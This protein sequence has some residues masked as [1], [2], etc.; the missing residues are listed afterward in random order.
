MNK[1]YRQFKI[2]E[3][4]QSHKYPTLKQILHHLEQCSFLDNK[5]ISA[6]TFERDLV[7]IH[8]N[9]GEEIKYDSNKKGYYIHESSFGAINASSLVNLTYIHIA[10]RLGHSENA[11]YTEPRV[12]KGMQFFLPMV[13]AIKQR[14]VCTLIHQKFDHSQ[15]ATHK[16]RPIQLREALGFWYIISY[17]EEFKTYALDRVIDFQPTEE[18]FPEP[19]TERVSNYYNNC[20]GILKGEGSPQVITFSAD[21]FYANYLRALPIH[22]SQIELEPNTFQLICFPTIDL[23][24]RFLSYGP[25]IKVLDN[26]FVKERLFQLAKEVSAHYADVV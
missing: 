24:Q 9:F 6:K 26:L 20:Y 11:I 21:D 22:P 19:N 1:I 16:I 14:K 4:I 17:G 7:E 15:A 5:R 23:L 13:E 3:Y 10:K 2:L 8:L 12:T 25:K 18:V